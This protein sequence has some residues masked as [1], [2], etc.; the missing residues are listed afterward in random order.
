MPKINKKIRPKIL[1]ID[2]KQANLLALEAVL[3]DF[4]CDIYSV[5]SGE[6]GLQ[7]ILK[8]DFALALLD[9][10]MPV[11]NGFEVAELIRG[12]KKSKYLPVIFITA[13]N[14][15]EEYKFK[16]YEAGAV[17]FLFKPVDPKILKSK[18]GVFLDLYKQKALVSARAAEL[19]KKVE[20]ANHEIDIRKQA[21]TIYEKNTHKNELFLDTTGDNFSEIAIP[22]QM[23]MG[24]V[25]SIEKGDISELE[26]QLGSLSALIEKGKLLELRLS[27][28]IKEGDFAG[29]L[30]LLETIKMV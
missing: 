8:H 5:T 15:K 24:F 4:E 11:M 21:Q 9:V 7:L 2:D 30:D 18:V 16:G 20:E 14:E 27:E 17:D 22:T 29:T 3:D 6:A 13:L 23:F 10:Q 28:L 1:A 12:I 19:K 26:K 25:E